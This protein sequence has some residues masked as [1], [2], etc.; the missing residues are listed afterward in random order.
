MREDGV[1]P[2][3]RRFA[4]LLG[5]CALDL[6]HRDNAGIVMRVLLLLGITLWLAG[7]ASSGDVM[8]NKPTFQASTVKTDRQYAEC[9]LAHWSRIS[10]AARMMEVADGFQIIVPNATTEAEEWLVVRSRADGAEVSLHERVE[11]LAM[12]AYRDSAKACL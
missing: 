3:I 8:R 11:V 10:P 5:V 12:R 2:F 4:A 9:V 1:N 7:C 6:K